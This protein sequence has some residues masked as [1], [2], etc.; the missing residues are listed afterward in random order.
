MDEKAIFGM[1]V[2][3]IAGAWKDVEKISASRRAVSFF[4]DIPEVQEEKDKKRLTLFSNVLRTVYVGLAGIWRSEYLVNECLQ[5]QE[6]DIYSGFLPLN[7]KSKFAP[8]LL[9][10]L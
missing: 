1:V 5:M 8:G 10:D 7:G 2:S 3:L 4:Y 6:K 9:F